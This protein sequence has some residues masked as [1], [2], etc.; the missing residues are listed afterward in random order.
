MGHNKSSAKKK[1]HSSECLQKELRGAYTSS[2]T[3][4]QKAL[5]QK[6]ANTPKSKRWEEINSGLKSTKYK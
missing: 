2:S 1:T 3:V 4:H 5:E 6:E